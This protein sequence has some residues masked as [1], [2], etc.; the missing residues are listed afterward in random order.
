M[1]YL[2]ISNLYK[3]QIIMLFKEA[4]AMEKI[5][6]TSAH[7]KWNPVEKRVH[8]FSGGEKHENFVKL[9]DEDFLKLKFL[10][11]FPD[12]ETVIFGEAYGGK[13]QGM[14]HTY[15]KDLKFIGFDVKVGETWLNVPN[16]EDVCNKFNV[17]FVYYE[18]IEVTL[19]NLMA[20]RDF[21]SIQ[22]IRNGMGEGKKREGIVLRPIVELKTSNGE[23]V[24]VKYKPDEYN[25]TKT[26][27]EISSDKLQI[28]EDAK[29]IAE[30]WVVPMRLE[31]ILQKFPEDV[32][33]ESLGE[34][35]KAMIEDVYR[36]GE[37]EIVE[38]K[39]VNKAIG[40]KTVQLFKQKLQS[41][42]K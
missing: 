4:F 27:R 15:G 34:I 5:H 17:E 10:E 40:G 35:I 24:I 3:S 14:S 1:G 25:E 19:E 18:K 2:H 33:M 16:A 20:Q 9:F 6:G 13:M 36:E 23:R 39:E 37:G 31:H 41:K 32:N 30:E 8:F 21:Q 29:A 22:A 7:I 26:K 28:L 12:V 38:S 11:F 42:L